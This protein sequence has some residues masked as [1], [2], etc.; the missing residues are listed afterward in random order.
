M[1]QEQQKKYGFLMC[2]C[3]VIGTVIGTGIFFK[4]E[5]VYGFVNGNGKLG[6][7]AWI[8][9][10]ITAIA[11]GLSFMEISSANQNS[12][13]GIALYAKLFIN[14][15]FGRVVR[16]AMNNIYFPL[17]CFTVAYYTTKA[18]IWA[19]GGGHVAEDSFRN[20]LGGNSNY[21][22]FLTIFAILYSLFVISYSIY[23]EKLSKWIQM[24][25][26][27]LK[28]LPL[29]VIGLVGLIITNRD[30][31]AFLDYGLGNKSNYEVVK[32]KNSFEM[33]LMALPG[34]LF[35][36]DGFLATTYIQKDVHKAK[37]NIPLALVIG[38]VTITIIYIVTSIATLNLDPSGSVAK[39]AG[40]IFNNALANIF[41]KRLIFIFIFI[42]AFG[43]LN[44]Y[45]FSMTKLTQSSLE[46]GF[47]IGNNKIWSKLLKRYGIKMTTM[48]ATLA[49]L[50]IW[51]LIMAIPT[52]ITEEKYN[53]FD[54]I[55][56]A[57]VIMSFM[58]YGIII[59]FGLIN[60]FTNKV[61]TIKNWYFI[62]TAIVSMLCITIIL[63]YNIYSY[64]D[65]LI[66]AN[67]KLGP[68]F[69]I[70]FLVLI[71]ALPW[72]GLFMKDNDMEIKTVVEVAVNMK[73]ND[74]DFKSINSESSLN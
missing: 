58:L 35:A 16:N 14:N 2:L 7:V 27:V 5:A 41:F 61:V 8:I 49:I 21:E 24:V 40:S 44:G 62:P 43:G 36:F 31:G 1:K 26:V 19:I 74:D 3:M 29:I 15:R 59:L 65:L 73:V 51:I 50:S 71:I 54:F 46:D 42:S 63:G 22:L 33:L 66:N 53:F 25:T 60:R 34:I 69:Q 57:A 68:L 32:D 6:I 47:M 67:N 56:N 70:L 12:N 64:F 48:L 23:Q 11:F 45:C 20:L 9:G 37:K 17:T 4:N 52:I 18:S 10:G 30:A 55:S 28:L 72:T 13:S 39:A 38:L